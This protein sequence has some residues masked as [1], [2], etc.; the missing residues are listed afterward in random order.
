M[1]LA[2]SR[3]DY[4]ANIDVRTGLLLLLLLLPPSLVCEDLNDL[5]G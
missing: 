2:C 1:Q 3:S 5:D 4:G